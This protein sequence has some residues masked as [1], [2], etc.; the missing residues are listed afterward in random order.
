MDAEPLGRFHL[1]AAGQFQ[2]LRE[3]WRTL[4]PDQWDPA[5]EGPVEY[6]MIRLLYRKKRLLDI[7]K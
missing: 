5:V 6:E 2:S 7:R 4:E 1:A 3:Y